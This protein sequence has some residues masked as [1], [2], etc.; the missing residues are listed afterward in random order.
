MKRK[1]EMCHN[2]LHPPPPLDPAPV[3][4]RIVIETPEKSS[5]WKVDDMC[6]AA[7]EG[8]L[9]DIITTLP[10]GSRMTIWDMISRQMT[11]NSLMLEFKE[12]GF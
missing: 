7:V 12:A 10:D 3:T 4:S 2:L 5:T 1:C 8:F 11:S 9:S 6:A